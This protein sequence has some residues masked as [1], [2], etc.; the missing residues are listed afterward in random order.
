M[1]LAF[2]PAVSLLGIY[3]EDLSPM[4]RRYICTRLLV[5]AL[6]A[7]MKIGNNLSGHT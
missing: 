4:T 5:V 2:D 6:F 3:P 1:H 7:I